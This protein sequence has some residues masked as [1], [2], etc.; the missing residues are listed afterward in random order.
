MARVR[1]SMSWPSL[2]AHATGAGHRPD[3]YAAQVAGAKLGATVHRHQA[4]LSPFKRSIYLPDLTS[5]HSERHR[6]TGRISFASRGSE[7]QIPSAPRKP[8]G[9]RPDLRS[10]WPASV[11]IVR[12]WERRCPILGADLEA[13]DRRGHPRTVHHVGSDGAARASGV[14]TWSWSSGHLSRARAETRR[15]PR[16]KHAIHDTDAWTT[17]LT[18][19]SSP[20]SGP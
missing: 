7:V 14:M 1:C 8:A 16:P 15:H 12:F 2:S 19:G 13:A 9:Q 18:Q 11:R 17:P 4:T 3:R 20:R 6:A 10:C 5:G